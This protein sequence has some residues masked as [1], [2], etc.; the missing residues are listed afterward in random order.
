MGKT[1]KLKL[2]IENI[3]TEEPREVML[4]EMEEIRM[5]LLVFYTRKRTCFC[6]ATLFCQYI[7][8]LS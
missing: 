3:A 7:I 4:K 1:R 5:I 2:S 6:L 8:L